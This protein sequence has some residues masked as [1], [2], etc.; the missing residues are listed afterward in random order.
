MVPKA[1][2]GTGGRGLAHPERAVPKRGSLWKLG[3][4]SGV[5]GKAAFGSVGPGSPAESWELAS[6]GEV[7]V[8][9]EPKAAGSTAQLG[10]AAFQQVPRAFLEAG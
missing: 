7:P 6:P 8:G 10:E 1:G 9:L 4:P 3:C 2:E 5:A